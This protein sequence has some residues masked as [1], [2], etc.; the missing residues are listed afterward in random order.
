M[1]VKYN[2]ARDRFE[3]RHYEDLSN[4]EIVEGVNNSDINDKK[5]IELKKKLKKAEFEARKIKAEIEDLENY[6]DVIGR[7]THIFN[8]VPVMISSS[9]PDED[10]P[11]GRYNFS[12]IGSYKTRKYL[13]AWTNAHL[14]DDVIL[15]TEEIWCFKLADGNNHEETFLA[16]QYKDSPSKN[17]FSMDFVKT[18]AYEYVVNDKPISEFYRNLSYWFEKFNR[19]MAIKDLLDS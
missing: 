3:V 5:L 8:G 17:G 12:G 4:K 6:Q 13:E 16:R 10:R 11:R 9:I 15:N 7:V 1:S 14:E 19:D 18:I 2:K